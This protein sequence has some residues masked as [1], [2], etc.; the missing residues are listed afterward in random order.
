[1]VSDLSFLKKLSLVFNP[2]DSKAKDRLWVET[3]TDVTVFRLFV[4]NMSENNL[5]M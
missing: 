5:T 3:I 1:M 4:I 2:A